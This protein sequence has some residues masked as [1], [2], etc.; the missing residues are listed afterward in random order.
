MVG[1]WC[2]PGARA[3]AA[4]SGYAVTT[5]RAVPGRSFGPGLHV[6]PAGNRPRCRLQHRRLLFPARRHPAHGQEGA[7]AAAR[8]PVLVGAASSQ[9][10]HEKQAVTL[11]QA[12]VGSAARVREGPVRRVDVD[13]E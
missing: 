10:L 1:S 4:G 7:R 11:Q 5:C 12:R 8:R 6:R 13:H 2:A 9:A 3:R